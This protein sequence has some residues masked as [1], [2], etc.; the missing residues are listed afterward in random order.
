V[1]AIL[2]QQIATAVAR[3]VRTLLIETYGPSQPFDG[4]THYAFPRPESLYAASVSELRQLKLSQRKAEYVRGIAAAALDGSGWLESMQGLTD[5]E[6]VRRVTGLRGVG[7]W[8][9]QWVLV[10]GLGRPDAFPSGDL[11]LQRA[12]SHLY[13]KGEK[14]SAGQIE[15]FSLRWSPFRS[16]ATA[17]LFSA[18]RGGLA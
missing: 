8:T 2:G 6:V 14:L 3:I 12:I 4:E 10:R 9:A 7:Q 13:F 11:A 15:D 17:Y 16:C 5:E 1:L 18:L